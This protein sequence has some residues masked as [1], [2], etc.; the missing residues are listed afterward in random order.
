MGLRESLMRGLTRSRE[1]I[2]EIFYLGGEVDDTFWEDLEDT[3][4]SRR[5]IRSVITDELKQINK[6]YP[7]P[8]KTG[9][10]YLDEIEEFEEEEEAEDYDVTLFLSREGYFKKITAQSLRMA[11][12][13]KYKEN[14]GLS[15][16]FAARNRDELL[17]FTDRQQVYKCR[18]SDFDDMKASVL[19]VYLPAH[20]NMD[21]GEAVLAMVLPGDYTKHLVF[22][23]ENGK[24]AKVELSGFETKTNR[25]KLTGA[26]CEKSP[27][28]AIIP[29]YEDAEA[30]VFSSDGRVIIF[31]TALLT[32]K[33]SKNTQ[34]VQVI[35][36]KKNKVVTEARL[37]AE[38]AIKNHSRY[39]ARRRR[40][41]QGRGH[42]QRTADAD[43]TLRRCGR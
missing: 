31:S 24:A 23:F 11:S 8:R 37:A 42:G 2:S 40:P 36:L 19:G 5:R 30:A 18:V 27:L 21:E 35:S 38:T 12:E 6:K 26:Y 3:L 16:S 4:K 15:Q 7:T 1:A 39:R 28:I 22:F 29:L 13:Q 41:S 34:G 10:V 9:I 17:V 43:V 32:P 14:D 25:K 20:L 33:Q